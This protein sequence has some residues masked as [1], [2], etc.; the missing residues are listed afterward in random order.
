MNSILITKNKVKNKR[1]QKTTLTQKIYFGSITLIIVLSGLITF[2]STMLLSINNQKAITGYTIQNLSRTRKNLVTSIENW[3]SK[4][5]FSQTIQNLKENPTI[6][7]MQ[8]ATS[9]DNTF[10]RGDVVVVLHEY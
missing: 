1:Y 7:R 5:S 8:S 9:N 2:T 3:E 6:A 4:T 10:I